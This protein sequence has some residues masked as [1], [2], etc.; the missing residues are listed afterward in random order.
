LE[1]IP[2]E[3]L[4]Y[5]TGAAAFREERWSD[6]L[7][8]WKRVLDL[9]P[10]SRRHR[11]TWAAY[12]CGR[13][14][15]KFVEASVIDVPHAETPLGDAAEA[16]RWFQHTRALAEDG[17]V[18]ALNLARSALGE[19]GRVHFL[20]G[21]NLEALRCYVEQLGAP[22]T[23]G[24]DWALR[25]VRQTAGRMADEPRGALRVYAADELASRIVTAYLISHSGKDDQRRRWM[26]VLG[27][28]ASP[29]LVD[30][31][32]RLAWLAYKNGDMETAGTLAARASPDE[33]M[34]SWVQAKL[35]LWDGDVDSAIALLTRTADAIAPAAVWW[36]AS[37][38][39]GRRNRDRGLHDVHGELA[40]LLLAREDYSAA[41]HYFLLG[42]LWADAAYVA[43]QVMDIPAL[44]SFVRKIETVDV[45][46]DVRAEE[47]QWHHR[48]QPMRQRL[49]H[50][51]ARRLMT[52]GR[53]DRAI[54]YYPEPYKKKARELARHL[55]GYWDESLDYEDR[56]VHLLDAARIVRGSGLELMSRELNPDWN[57]WSGRFSMGDDA[58]AARKS[59]KAS[60]QDTRMEPL[61]ASD[62]EL[63]RVEAHRVRPDRRFHYRS[64][65]S[66]MMWT[67]ACMLPDNDPRT[68]KALYLGGTY[69]KRK[70]PMEADRFYKALVNRC[71][72]LPIGQ[73]AD[74]LR[75]FPKSFEIAGP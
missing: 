55:Q 22:R 37:R 7:A 39:W 75:W 64:L 48:G 36:N 16:V 70:Y 26:E 72:K 50:L 10:E 52:D 35:A 13:I 33:P 32:D 46:D 45:Y 15:L 17:Y 34:V 67:S 31:A 62:G 23:P 61:L 47:L 19:E 8:A 69:L 20:L 43:E 57:V 24:V 21:R 12:M 53:W 66:Q 14:H 28:T 6:A 18:D 25:S 1:A 63:E 2:E 71:R 11:S 60:N 38:R 58:A 27:E 73:E 65:A 49:S 54:P 30:Y 59:R 74:R 51:L 29:T 5:A 40:M 68:A 9:P 3:F 44:E 4:G 42:G 56:A 41:L